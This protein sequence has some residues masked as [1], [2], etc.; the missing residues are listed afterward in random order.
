MSENN[1]A[2]DPEDNAVL[3]VADIFFGRIVRFN[4]GYI[5]LNGLNIFF[6]F[7]NTLLHIITST[8]AITVFLL[9]NRCQQGDNV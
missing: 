8:I 9:S 5:S 3:R 2:Y 7:T 4:N 6:E 1:S